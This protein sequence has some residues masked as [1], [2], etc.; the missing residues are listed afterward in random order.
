MAHRIRLYSIWNI[1]KG[2]YVKWITNPRIVT[3]GILI[4]FI[5]SFAIQ[6]MLQRAEKYGEPLN[7]FEPFLAVCNSGMM[8]L[9]IPIVFIILMSDFP[10][11]GGNT[12]FTVQRS[13]KYNWLW[14][15]IL[16]V[17]MCILSYL[18]TIFISCMIMSKGVFD[19]KWSNAITLYDSTYPD[20]AGGFVS[21]LLPPN[22]YNQI[23]LT[24]ALIN[25]ALLLI[26]CLFMF[27]LIL[28]LMK[29]LYLR[30]CGLFIVIALCALG[31]ITCALQ[32]HEQWFFPTSN[33][34]IWLHYQELLRK[35]AFPVSGSYL[36]FIIGDFV[37]L[38]LNIFVVNRLEFKNIEQEGD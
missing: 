23:P 1:A 16:F 34:M 14:G 32:I 37:L 21:K 5:H 6:P 33:T 4:T 35:A 27:A 2:E 13:G 29:I 17:F 19:N 36:Y 11:M 10:V 24:T 3:V 38:I 26:L 22:L 18:T 15:Q 8:M 28:S 9:F 25:T 12:L 31:A 7:V 30:T 20:E